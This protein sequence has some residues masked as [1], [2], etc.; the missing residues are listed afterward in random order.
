MGF[1]IGGLLRSVFWV[2]GV[3]GGSFLG[4]DRAGVGSLVHGGGDGGGGLDLGWYCGRG[5][6]VA[7]GG[8]EW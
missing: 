3:G 6:W 5:L 7:V 4:W 2:L 8:C 1:V